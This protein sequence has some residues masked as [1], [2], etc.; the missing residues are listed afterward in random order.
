[1]KLLELEVKNV[2]PFKHAKLDLDYEGITV[3]KGLNKDDGPK[4]SNAAGKSRLVASLADLVLDESPN[5]KEDPSK[6]KNRKGKR[7]TRKSAIRVR[8]MKG[9]HE[10][11][12]TKISGKGKT[13]EILKDGKST[14]VRTVK[15]SQEKIQKLFGLSETQFYT[16]FYIDGTIPHTLITGSTKHRQEFIVDLFDL[17]NIDSVRK[18]LN[19]ELTAISKKAIEYK[20][21]KSTLSDLREDLLPKEERRAIRDRLEELRTKQER[22][23]ETLKDSQ[24]A[25]QLLSFE[26]QNKPLLD[27]LAKLNIKEDPADDLQALRKEIGRIRLDQEAHHEWTAYDK[28][29]SAWKLSFAP[30]QKALDKLGCDLDTAKKRAREAHEFAAQMKG[31]GPAREPGKKPELME[32]PRW[33]HDECKL[34][35]KHFKQELEHARSF[36]DGKCSLCGSKVKSRPAE[37]I[38]AELDKWVKR[39]NACEAYVLYESRLKE[40]KTRKE[41]YEQNEQAIADLSRKIEK[42]S[43]YVDVVNLAEGVRSKPQK[44][45]IDRP[46]AF[47]ADKL[48]RLERRRELLRSIHDVWPTVVELHNLTDKQREAASSAEKHVQR[49]NRV[50]GEMSDL[51]TKNVR[52]QEV[53]R[54]MRD[55]KTKVE[56]L[57]EECKDEKLLKALV[58]AYSTSG[59]KKFMIERYSKLLEQQVNK[60]RKMFFSEDYEFEFQYDAGLRV[61]VHRSYGKRVETS[62][63]RKLSGAEKRFFTLLLVVATNTLLP[64]K[65]RVNVLI[66]DEPESQMGEPAIERFV[67]TLT[68]LRKLVPHIVV[69]T[70]KTNLD[71]PDSRGFTVVKQNGVSTL[72][73]DKTKTKTQ[74]AEVI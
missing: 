20:T 17:S 15:Y 18:L 60:Y 52:Q 73:R 24:N 19:N 29:H 33:E 35:V 51:T 11:S 38:R 67:K 12:V 59:L 48:E 69:V 5:G 43:R 56:D 62:D 44:P 14:D 13:Y 50:L 53:I 28:A 74:D 21:V 23:S 3:I 36:K 61:L 34:K 70:P 30:V 58:G 32:V 26:R 37:E 65:K 63:V 68:I 4:A 72:V 45:L 64:A 22:L 16:R 8:L 46:E 7:K 6:I 55:L 42:R 39:I 25:S 2:V 41:A 40:W 66:L 47:D 31:I 27:R 57:Y 10:Y 1:M 49:L 54:R 9:K 71:I